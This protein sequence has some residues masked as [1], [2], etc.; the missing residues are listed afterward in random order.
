MRQVLALHC[1]LA[2][3]AAWR[4]VQAALPGAELTCPD[5]PG[6][7]RAPDWDSGP[8][9]D[10]ALALAMAVAPE[11]AFDLIGHSYGGCVAL[12]LLADFPDRVRSLTVI[13]PV[14]FAAAAADLRAAQR[15]DMVGFR[16]AL[17]AGD[18]DAAARAFTADWGDGGGWDAMAERQRVYI[19]DRI[20]LIAASGPGIA[21]DAH[22]VLDR[23]PTDGGPVSVVVQDNPPAI[24]AGIAAGLRARM[25][26]ATVT[27]LGRDHMIP[28]TDASGL[29]AHLNAI[30]KDVD[31]TP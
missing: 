14:M 9:M 29:A 1:M 23:L 31:P 21:D 25:P 26:Q 20:H 11:G 27:Y 19:R 16:T 13:E 8:F 3:G 7:G 28:I 17:Q 22:G 24:V 18:R 5:L 15:D 10:Q 6:H 4:G 12:R 2:S 30:W